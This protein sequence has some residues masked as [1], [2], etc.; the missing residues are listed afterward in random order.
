VAGLGWE[1]VRAH[2]DALLARALEGLGALEHVT[3][4]GAAAERTPTLMFTVAA[5]D[6]R[7]VATALAGREVAVWNGNYYAW[8][9]ECHLGLAPHG[10]VRAGFVHYNDEGD[11]DRLVEA[12]RALAATA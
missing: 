6:T 5:R 9:L 11:A 12:V 7:A 4:I 1:E 3:L 8:E 2:E 10:G